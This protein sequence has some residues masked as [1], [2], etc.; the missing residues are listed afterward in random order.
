MSLEKREDLFQ[1]ICPECLKVYHL[2]LQEI[3]EKGYEVLICVHCGIPLKRL[4]EGGGK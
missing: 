3:M 4:E 1:Y 2:E